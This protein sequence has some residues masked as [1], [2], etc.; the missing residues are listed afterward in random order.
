MSHG[1][2]YMMQL[3]TT[4]AITFMPLSQIGLPMHKKLPITG[5]FYRRKPAL[6]TNKIAQTQTK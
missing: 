2:H 5:F 3:K 4:L 1:V 6:K